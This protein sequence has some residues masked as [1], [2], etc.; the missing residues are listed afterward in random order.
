MIETV[1]GRL[2]AA[3]RNDPDAL[4]ALLTGGLPLIT[5]DVLARVEVPVLLV[6]GSADFTGPADR[7]A[8]LLPDATLRVVTGADH[9]GLPS[10]YRAI[11]AASEFLH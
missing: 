6:I 10:D 2:V 1:F 4:R 7:L 9:F 11:E 8:E 3:A 5:E